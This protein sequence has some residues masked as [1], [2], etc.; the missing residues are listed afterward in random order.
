M[1]QRSAWMFLA[2]MGVLG[3]EARAEKAWGV[4]SR[5]LLFSFDTDRPQFLTNLLLFTGLKPGEQVMAIDFRPA[6][7]QLYALGS[8][9]HI[10]TID[11]TSGKATVVGSGAAFTP[12]LDGTQF[13]FN[14][15]PTVDRIRVTS[16]TGQNLRLHP[17]TG[18]VA[19]VDGM[20]SYADGTKPQIIAS[21]YTNSFVGTTTTALYNI[22]AAKSAVVLQAPPNEGTLAM[23]KPLV[24][25]DF[26]GIAGFDISAVTNRGYMVMRESK[27]QRSILYEIYYETGDH[28]PIGQVW[29]FEQ[30]SGFAV[31]PP[32]AK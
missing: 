11:R 2:L 24:N 30:V 16:N 8:T 31:E 6:T 26:S 21:A 5:A 7:G 3:V 27:T 12:A 28:N 23:I 22:D 20:L 25:L 13:G 32:N 17:D 1:K 9:S 10:Y 14:F 29:F 19:A 18:V 15:N 4:D